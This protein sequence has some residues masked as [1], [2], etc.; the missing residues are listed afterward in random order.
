MVRATACDAGEPQDGGD[1]A[2]TTGTTRLLPV[3]DVA[4]LRADLERLDRQQWPLQRAF[5]SG[6]AEYADFDWRAL[7]LRSSTGSVER[8]DPGGAGLDDF[9]ATETAQRPVPGVGPRGGQRA[10][11]PRSASPGPICACYMQ[12]FQTARELGCQEISLG[13]DPAFYGHVAKPGLFGFKSARR[14][15]HRSPPGCS[16]A[17]WTTPTRPPGSSA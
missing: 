15:A 9:A 8:T 11:L 10:A 14:F 1:T 6:P 5:E 4:R 12:A 7:P 3:F 16:A 13:T 2:P 17:P